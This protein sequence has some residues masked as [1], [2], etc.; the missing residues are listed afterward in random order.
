MQQY[1]YMVK[2]ISTA[3]VF[4]VSP[5]ENEDEIKKLAA[6]QAFEQIPISTDCDIID[7][8]PVESPVNWNRGIKMEE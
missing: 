5:S 1:Q 4:V 7:I 2:A 8:W 6:E 3:L